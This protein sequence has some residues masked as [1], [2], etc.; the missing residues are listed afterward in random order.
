MCMYIYMHDSFYIFIHTYI[1]IYNSDPVLYGSPIWLQPWDADISETTDFILASKLVE[2]PGTDAISIPGLEVR[3]YICINP[4][5]D[6][7]FICTNM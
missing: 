6:I 4:Y 2:L 1:F 7:F 5:M 3:I